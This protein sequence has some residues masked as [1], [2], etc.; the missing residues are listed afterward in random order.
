M[1]KRLSVAVLAL[2]L[3][4]FP[5]LAAL[6]TVTLAVENMTCVSCPYIVKESLA[7]VHGVRDLSS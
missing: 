2:G 3:L 1:M 6:K 5:A 4:A 7:A